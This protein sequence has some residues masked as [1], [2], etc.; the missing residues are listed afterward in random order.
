MPKL[1]TITLTQRFRN[2]SHNQFFFLVVT[3]LVMV[4][5]DQPF[6]ELPSNNSEQSGRAGNGSS[7]NLRQHDSVK[8]I[9]VRI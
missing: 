3:S 6:R 1:L 7:G 9:H 5:I 8:P 4:P 2:R